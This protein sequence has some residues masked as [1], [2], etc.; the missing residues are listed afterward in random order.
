MVDGVFCC[1]GKLAPFTTVGELVEAAAFVLRQ[2]DFA[3]Q[4]GTAASECV[5]VDQVLSMGNCFRN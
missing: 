4:A 2:I 5:G 1:F 3:E